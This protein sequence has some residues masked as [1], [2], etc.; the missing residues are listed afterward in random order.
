MSDPMPLRSVWA[1]L[2]AVPVVMI[3]VALYIGLW[4]ISSK[5]EDYE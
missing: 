5:D 2:A 1:G 4:I 3:V